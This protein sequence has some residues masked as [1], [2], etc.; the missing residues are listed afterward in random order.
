MIRIASSGCALANSSAADCALPQLEHAIGVIWALDCEFTDLRHAGEDCDSAW[1]AVAKADG[2]AK[3]DKWCGEIR[4][5]TA[6]RGREVDAFGTAPSVV[7]LLHPLHVVQHEGKAPV[8]TG[9]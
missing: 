8:P 6:A 2:E 1:R 3:A 5:C 7:T 9:R 4:G